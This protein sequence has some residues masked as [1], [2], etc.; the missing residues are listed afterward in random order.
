MARQTE[1]L[2]LLVQ[3]QQNQH[4]QQSRGGR[5]GLNPK[6]QAIKISSVPSPHFSVKLKNLWMPMPGFILLNRS[7]PFLLYLVWTQ[8]KLTLPP[9]NFV[10]LPAF[11]GIIFAPCSPLDMLSPGRNFRLPSGHIIFLKD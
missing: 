8:V 2:N 9:N 6:W 11:G 4:R 5:D 7:S 10:V 1:L 3:A